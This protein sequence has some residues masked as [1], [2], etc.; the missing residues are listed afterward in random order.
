[1]DHMTSSPPP[2]VANRGN[3]TLDSVDMG[4]TKPLRRI[5]ENGS[6][7]VPRAHPVRLDLADEL[8]LVE[9][10]AKADRADA[11]LWQTAARLIRSRRAT[12]AQVAQLLD[13]AER[14]VSRR[15]RFAD[16]SAGARNG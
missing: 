13:V 2:V 9:A 15:I 16:R 5:G 11:Q 4:A 14:T 3:Y 7:L 10:K 6:P 8:A 1:M 12:R